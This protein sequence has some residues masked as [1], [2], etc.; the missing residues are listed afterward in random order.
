V[1]KIILSLNS[2]NLSL[3]I[4]YNK[5]SSWTVFTLLCVGGN[6]VNLQECG[7]AKNIFDVVYIDDDPLMAELFNQFISWK[8]Q[9]WHAYAF[10]DPVVVLQQVQAGEVNARV[11]IIDLMMPNTNGVELAAAVR[12]QYGPDAVIVG[13]TALETQVLETDPEYSQGLDWFNH[14]MRKNEGIARLLTLAD[15]EVRKQRP[16]EMYQPG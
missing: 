10:T 9:H 6:A 13:Y 4:G 5:I 12:A 11:W 7:V 16:L 1:N 8:Y 15:S 14:L 3:L 2:Y